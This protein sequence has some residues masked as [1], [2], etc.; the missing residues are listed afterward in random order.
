M[1]LSESQKHDLPIKQGCEQEVQSLMQEMLEK[2]ASNQ[3]F[4]EIQSSLSELKLKIQNLSLNVLKD[5][6][7]VSELQNWREVIVND[8]GLDCV[9][10]INNFTSF[11]SLIEFHNL[12]KIAE[13]R[14]QSLAEILSSD[15]FIKTVF[16]EIIGAVPIFK[17]EK[18]PS[19]DLLNFFINLQNCVIDLSNLSNSIKTSLTKLPDCTHFKATNFVLPALETLKGALLL[20]QTEII[21]LPNLE[22]LEGILNFRS[23]KEFQAAKLKKVVGELE[24]GL[25]AKPDLTSLEEVSEKLKALQ[26]DLFDLP[27]LIKLG[28]L[29]CIDLKNLNIPKLERVE[30]RLKIRHLYSFFAPSLQVVEG[31]FQLYKIKIFNADNLTNIGGNLFIPNCKKFKSQAL[32]EVN[33]NLNAVSVSNFEAGS[34]Q[35]VNGDL[36]LGKLKKYDLSSLKGVSGELSIKSCSNLILNVLKKVGGINFASVQKLSLNQLETVQKDLIIKNLPKINLP[37]LNEVKGDVNMYHSRNFQANNLTKVGENI[38]LENCRSFQAES[39]TSV[40]GDLHLPKVRSFS[41]ANLVHVAGKITLN[42]KIKKK[43]HLPSSLH[44]KVVFV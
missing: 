31:D 15:S 36:E 38:Y 25:I 42:K 21:A 11:F 7:K 16:P 33:G 2:I 5:G 39:L 17:I 18:N 13:K 35:T 23:A 30:G 41:A 28:S 44:N 19:P 29:D 20:E 40:G 34:L 9:K 10:N 27:N 6:V 12:I 26:V 4:A 14:G 3:S 43:I 24:I 1:N 8:Y 32:N 22:Y 37:A